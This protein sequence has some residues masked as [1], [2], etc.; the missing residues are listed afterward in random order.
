MTNA[1]TVTTSRANEIYAKIDNPMSAIVEMGKLF[2]QSQIMGISTAGD[3]AVLALTCMCEGITPLEF[4][5]T[6]HII[7]GKPSMRSD[8]MAAKFQ[9]AGG[10][11][12]WKNIGDDAKEARAVF[13]FEGQS[14]EMVYTIEDAKKAKGKNAQG[15]EVVDTPDGNWMKDRGSMLRA[16]LITKSVRI[17]APGIIAGVY[18][19]DEIEDLGG[20][21]AEP[22]KVTAEARKKRVKELDEAAATTTVIVDSEGTGSK[23]DVTSGT[24]KAD[25]VIID[26][27]AETKTQPVV[28][29]PPFETSDIV[30]PEQLR[31]LA[32]SGVAA[33]YTVQEI[34]Q[35]A[36]SLY[37]A[38]SVKKI[39]TAQASELANRF[40]LLTEAIALG[41]KSPSQSD[42]S[43]NMRRD[44]L[45]QIICKAVEVEHAW[46]SPDV[47]INNLINALRARLGVT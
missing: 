44:E 18:I 12:L 37:G 40:K 3:G 21:T 16:R 30:N 45:L 43:S 19:A 9:A 24:V 38:E 41:L 33:G 6:Y 8:A 2:H 36:I 10:K 29:T 14:L 27:V 28:E 42:K 4:A 7:K 34:N 5:R 46:M 15:K 26:V 47:R 32:G 17:L 25:D 23:A 31:T 39:T 35:A 11:I 22:A 13:E 1:L 20:D